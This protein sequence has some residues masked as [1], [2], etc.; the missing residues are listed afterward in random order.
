LLLDGLKERFAN[1]IHL[2]VYDFHV[3]DKKNQNQNNNVFLVNLLD[4]LERAAIAQI[5]LISAEKQNRQ[6]LPPT[7]VIN[8]QD[9]VKQAKQKNI[10]ARAIFRLSEN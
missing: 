1:L 4:V 9:L 7:Q 3:L 10:E 8:E 6:T 2:F 5:N